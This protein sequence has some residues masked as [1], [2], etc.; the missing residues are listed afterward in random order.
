MVGKLVYALKKLIYYCHSKF[1]KRMKV[2]YY[3]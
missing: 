2:I 3:T 1:L